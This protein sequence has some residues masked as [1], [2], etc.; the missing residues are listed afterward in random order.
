MS[1]RRGALLFGLCLFS[2]TAFTGAQT[3]SNEQLDVWKTIKAEWEAGKNKDSDRLNR[4]LHEK[5]M[6][7]GNE[8]PAPRNRASVVM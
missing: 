5:F 1:I 3:W 2:F 4:V 7:W 6:G 8:D